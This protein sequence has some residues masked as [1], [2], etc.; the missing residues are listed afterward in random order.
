MTNDEIRMMKANRALLIWGHNP[1]ILAR[2]EPYYKQKMFKK[3]SE[4]PAPQ[5][6]SELAI[7]TVPILPLPLYKVKTDAA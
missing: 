5:M 6:K 4:L 7:E 2:L 3:N 1:P